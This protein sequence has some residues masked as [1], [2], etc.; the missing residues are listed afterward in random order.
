MTT[1]R[2]FVVEPADEAG[3]QGIARLI[4]EYILKH[5]LTETY[6]HKKKIFYEEFN[7]Q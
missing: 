3:I 4:Y 7:Q 1:T 5:C 6:W 2:R